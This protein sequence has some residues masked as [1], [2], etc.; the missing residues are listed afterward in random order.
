MRIAQDMMRYFLGSGDI[1][2]SN[3]PAL[4]VLFVLSMAVLVNRIM[5]RHHPMSL[6]LQAMGLLVAVVVVPFC[7]H[8]LNAGDMPPRAMLAI[9]VVLAGIVVLAMRQ[10]GTVVRGCLWVLIVMC[11]WQF[12]VANNRLAMSNYM[13][14]LSDRELTTRILD[15]V[16][17]AMDAS[18][19]G[20]HDSIRLELVG[21]LDR[22]PSPIFVQRST[23]GVSFYDWGEGDVRRLSNLIKT[24][25]YR[26]Y[27]PALPAQRAA[28]VAV[29][30][31]MPV[32]PRAG[33]VQWANGVVVI[34]LSEYTPQQL[35]NI[36]KGYTP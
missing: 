23:V 30:Q 34:K 28:V 12:A 33:S 7:F 29:A 11:G 22:Q 16:T 9:P 4:L 27:K 21:K 18:G 17:E 3:V 24:M 31:K 36:N 26:N 14:W 8:G 20:D 15:R 35:E 6:K 19:A 13:G 5:R 25:G 2:V 32:W 10:A 1:Y